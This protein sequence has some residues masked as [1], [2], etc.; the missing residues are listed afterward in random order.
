M[1]I[2]GDISVAAMQVILVAVEVDMVPMYTELFSLCTCP[3]QG[4]FMLCEL[5]LKA[6]SALVEAETLFHDPWFSDSFWMYFPV[7]IYK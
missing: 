3:D 4:F 1:E 7:L 5:R 6:T 2:H